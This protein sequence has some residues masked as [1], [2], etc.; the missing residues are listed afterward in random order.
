[1]DNDD[2]VDD[3]DGDDDEIHDYQM[4]DN[5]QEI[6]EEIQVNTIYLLMLMDEVI[7]H[8]VQKYV[9]QYQNKMI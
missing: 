3:D 9:F 2:N 8:F 5:H 1:M 6:V 4:F 7:E